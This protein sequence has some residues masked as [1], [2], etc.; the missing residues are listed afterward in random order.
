MGKNRSFFFLQEKEQIF[1]CE[2]LGKKEMREIK[3]WGFTPLDNC[4]WLLVSQAVVLLTSAALK[5][6]M[7][8]LTL[9]AGQ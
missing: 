1:G 6:K 9:H 8:G 7:T 5:L 3:E 4:G 2:N